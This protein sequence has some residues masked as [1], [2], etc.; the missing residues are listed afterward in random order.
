M[1]IATTAQVLPLTSRLKPAIARTVFRVPV[2]TWA[3]PR[4]AV[5]FR[6]L[7]MVPSVPAIG[8][9]LMYSAE[10]GLCQAASSIEAIS[11]ALTRSERDRPEPFSITRCGAVMPFFASH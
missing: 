11:R 5:V 8:I 10:Y 4:M 1:R 6:R 7:R 9:E 3:S 2:L